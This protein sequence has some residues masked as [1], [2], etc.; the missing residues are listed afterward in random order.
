M[1]AREPWLLFMPNGEWDGI[2]WSPQTVE[3]ARRKFAW[4]GR[5]RWATLERQGWTV[6]RGEP[7]EHL[8]LLS[9]RIGGVA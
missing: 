2:S 4:M 3:E 5:Q 1:S 8:R 9:E 7:G 6:R